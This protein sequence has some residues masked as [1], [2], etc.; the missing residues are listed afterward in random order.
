[1]FSHEDHLRRVDLEQFQQVAQ[2]K[3]CHPQTLGLQ[4]GVDLELQVRPQPPVIP[5]MSQE[6]L[7]VTEYAEAYESAANKD[8]LPF[9]KEQKSLEL[10]QR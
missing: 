10:E 9:R 7:Q 4:L 1:M 5:S 8:N 3:L 6:P 2:Q